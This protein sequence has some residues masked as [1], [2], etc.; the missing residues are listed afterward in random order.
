MKKMIFLV[1]LAAMAVTANAAD[2]YQVTLHSNLDADL[3]RSSG[4]DVI[5]R[6]G[7]DY[8]VLAD[9]AEALN[10]LDYELIAAD[11]EMNEIAIDRRRD[12]L[13]LGKYEL[14]YQNDQVR[15][16]KVSPSDLTPELRTPDLWP[17][18][19]HFIKIE[20]TP[21]T[22]IDQ[23]RL[24]IALTADLDS[25]ANLIEQD[26][27]ESYLYRLEAFFRRVA[28]TDSNY[29]A[30]DW[31]KSKFLDF[32]YADVYLDPFVEQIGPDMENCYNVVAV[33]EGTLYPDLQIIVGAHFD[34]VIG[35][36]AADDN[37]TGVAGVLEMA[38]VL[39]D[40]ETN[41]TFIFI[42]F[43]AEEWG[44]FGSYHY[45][46]Q[47]AMRGDD[48]L[49][50]FNMDM[51]GNLP[52]DGEANLYNG[53]NSI[54]AQKWID[55]ADTLVDITGYKLGNSPGSDHFPFSEVG[56]HSI[57]LHEYEFSSVYHSNHDSTTYVNFDYCT[58]MIKAS[59]ATVYAISQSDDFDEDGVA[60]DID[61]CML[62]PNAS[63]ADNDS[64]LLGD[65]CDNCPDV[66]N[67]G[68]EDSDGDGVGDH[69]DGRPHV[70]KGALPVGQVGEYYEAQLA[71]FG[72]VE[73]YNWS[74]I[75]GQL[76]YG[77]VLNGGTVG[78]L[79]GVPIYASYFRFK[80]KLIDSSD[81]PLQDEAWLTVTINPP[82]YD[83][84]DANTDGVINISDAVYIIGYVFVGGAPPSPLDLGDVNC[85]GKVGLT[86]IVYMINYVFRGGYIPCDTNGDG[87]PD[88]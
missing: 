23:S 66:Y 17:L 77:C 6:L 58:R 67:P 18:R 46:E 11:I 81:P 25:I 74:H 73:P 31:I 3:L 15:L 38:R 88:C 45:A 36:P 33:K 21:A 8:L 35:S 20:Y 47:A 68:Q 78:I 37:G 43:D 49:L 44:L 85:D 34:G 1:M 9:M 87:T 86:D 55:I 63:Q 61:N 69:C 79:T 50:M 10:G 2:L 42:S 84:G 60:N 70:F 71:G 26:S 29:A 28:G 59:L 7:N 65:A 24:S 16:L 22:K 39:A 64:D 76:P 12:D 56:Y 30:R 13:N 75:G 14:L 83:C 19:A 72:G 57:F 40:M 27:V 62:T 54:F 5:L 80:I 41:L 32:G 53:T 82:I 48:I 51:I 52:N 4:Q